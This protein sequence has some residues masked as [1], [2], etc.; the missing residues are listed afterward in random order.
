[1]TKRSFAF[2]APSILFYLL[3]VSL[4]IHYYLPVEYNVQGLVNPN[5]FDIRPFLERFADMNMQLI[6]SATGINYYGWFVVIFLLVAIFDAV[7]TDRWT[8]ETKN[9]LYAVLVIWIG[10]PL[11][12]YLF[13]LMD[14]HNSTKRA[15]FKIF[16]L[17]LL[18]MGHS[19]VL[20]E[21]SAR[22]ERWEK[23]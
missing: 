8:R 9:W 2:L 18:Y 23:N 3:T 5:L 13:P 19:G 4:Y 14:L 22:L 7:L 15:L 17:M 16:P 21:L 1:M 10:L 20:M 11:I 12:G 6:F